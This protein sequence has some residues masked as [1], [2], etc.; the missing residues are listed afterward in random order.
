MPLL[1]TFAP[2]LKLLVVTFLPYVELR[3]SIPLGI[4]LGMNPTSVFLVCTSANVLIIPP[5]LLLLDIGFNWFFRIGWARRHVYTRVE[6]FRR[7]AARR[8]GRYGLWGLAGFVAI[9]LPG[10]GAYSGCLAA[11]LL[12]M[13]KKRSMVAVSAGVVAAGILVTLASVGFL[14]AL[15]FGMA[16]TVALLAVLC[17]LTFFAYRWRRRA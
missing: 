10:T 13:E 6:H 2:Y 12:G 17:V 5:I 9:P 11:Y 1:Q 16:A 3:G 4:A 8:V 7:S 14:K 15:H